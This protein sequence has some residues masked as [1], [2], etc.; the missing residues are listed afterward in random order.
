MLCSEKILNVYYVYILETVA[1][2]GKK[3]Y[4]TGYTNDL[5][6]RWTQH[7]KGKGAKFCRGKNIELK[8]FE[9]Y[10]T[11]KE[12]MRRELEIKSFSKLQKKE[13]IKN[14]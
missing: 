2:D 1:K 8:H 7:R 14:N 4:Y 13:L 11:R 9:T 5:L 12:A 6:R 10:I 3:R